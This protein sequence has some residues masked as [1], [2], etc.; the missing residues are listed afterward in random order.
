MSVIINQMED[1]RLEIRFEANRLSQFVS[2]ISEVNNVVV[3][4]AHL[5][6]RHDLENIDPLKTDGLPFAFVDENGNTKASKEQIH[7][8][9]FKKAF[10]DFTVGLTQSLIEAYTF[11]RM[12]ALVE[13]YETIILPDP[14]ILQKELDSITTKA[15]K[16]NFPTLI[17]DIGNILGGP[18]A[19]KE[20]ILSINQVRNCLVHKNSI[21]TDS[22]VLQLKFL[23]MRMWVQKDGEMVELTKEVKAQRFHAEKLD[24]RQMPASLEFKTGEHIVLNADIF[25]DV[26]YTCILFI[27]EL[28]NKLPLEQSAKDQ[29][30]RPFSLNLAVAE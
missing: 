29:L 4:I 7:G 8:W 21:V 30:V 16:L 1:G 5:A 27:N 24:I 25:K 17:S 6:N 9:V 26:T 23:K 19:L 20:E 28:I 15:H 13:A 2:H 12:M 18:L 10:E 14:V 22:P 11:L 3:A